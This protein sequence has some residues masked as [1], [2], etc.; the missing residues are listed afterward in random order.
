MRKAVLAGLG[1]AATLALGGTAAPALAANCGI[2]AGF[3]GFTDVQDT[4]T[5]CNSVQWLRNRQITVGCTST[6]E[7]CPLNAVTR[8]SMALFLNRLGN[9]ITPKW[10]SLRAG[11][12]G[13]NALAPTNSI[14]VCETLATDLPAVNYPQRL[15]ARGTVSAPIS[16]DA[17]GLA[18]R[19]SLNGGSI[20]SMNT[21]STEL[22]LNNPTGDQ[23]LHWSASMDVPPGNSVSVMIAII[24]RGAG[25]LTIGGGGRCAIE[26][27]T[28]SA[29]SASAPF[30][31][32][33]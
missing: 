23:L 27:E 5:I 2:D 21:M 24:N 4:D 16:G 26:V 33:E 30:D 7:Y 1:L 14:H 31:T 17:V 3:T 28:V 10:V 12:G 8:G 11:T 6:T 13:G 29:I 25:T 32:D 9:A 18:V 22:L 15:R 20:F 19:R